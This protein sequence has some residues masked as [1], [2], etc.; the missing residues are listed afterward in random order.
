MFQL[1]R[2][3]REA[4]VLKG[5][6][7]SSLFFLKYIVL[8]LFWLKC[9]IFFQV[10]HIFYKF[11]VKILAASNEIRCVRC[12]MVRKHCYNFRYFF[13]L[14][15]LYLKLTKTS[16]MHIAGYLHKNIATQNIINEC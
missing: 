11:D 7:P 3:Q 6:L 15:N 14:F 2:F 8:R 5:Q 9:Q 13:Y 1:S 16:R 12:S 10:D 4:P